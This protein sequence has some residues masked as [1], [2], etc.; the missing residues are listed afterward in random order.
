MYPVYSIFMDPL[1][2]NV[3]L[4]EKHAK[5]CP[6]SCAASPGGLIWKCM[7]DRIKT[8][9]GRVIFLLVMCALVITVLVLL[10]SFDMIRS[11]ERRTMIQSVEFNFQLISSLVEQDLRDL[12]SLAWWC[13]SNREIQEFLL[14]EDQNPARSISAW[15][16]LSEEYVNNRSAPYVRRLIV[17]DLPQEKFIQVGNMA[18]GSVPVT[19][20]NLGMIF[21]AQVEQNSQWQTLIQD[22]YTIGESPVFPLV[23][24]VYSFE[25]GN[26]IGT[27]FLAASSGIITDKLKGYNPPP[28][29]R[30][31]LNVG[32]EYY[33]I[34][35]GRMAL[36]E[37]HYR[38]DNGE[39]AFPERAI[40]SVR[41]SDG[42]SLTL[43]RYPVRE[44]IVLNQILPDI[45]LFPLR[46]TWP[47]LAAGLGA[48]ILLL[49]FMGRGVNRMTRE[50]TELMDERLAD[51][52]NKRDLE[53]RMLQSQINPHFLYNTL[54]SIKWM[55]SIQNASGI[56]EMTTALSRL[57]RTIS[58][59][60]RTMVPLKDELATLDEYLVIQKYRYGDSV[61]MEKKIPD[62]ALLDT[63]IPR[64][65][66]QPLIENAIFHGIEPR[67]SGIITIEVKGQGDN[68]AVS[69]T[70]NGVGMNSGSIDAFRK[71][72]GIFREVGMHN[73]DERLR[74]A[75]GTEYGLS[76]DSEEGKFT[77]VTIT[78]PAAAESW[79][80]TI[81][82]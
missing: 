17:F 79:G 35:D 49:I 77:T 4:Y 18:S 27:V 24:S 26:E 61:I 12:S 11:F 70:D 13:V 37:F 39:N 65:V 82:G 54:N 5:Y 57:L 14:S 46:G 21:A 28:N 2:N 20:Y 60:S 72:E 68:V 8:V 10:F 52:K 23:S 19:A 45:G 80:G 50:I 1:K 42:K 30:F 55:A 53:Y 66:L 59:D 16:R 71:S 38:G 51:E 25:R 76:I 44:G 31:Y 78:L 73:V 48:L 74:C 56:A 63:M 3:I 33:R 29:S 69:V 64:F 41:D 81:N 22:P 75:F 9:K 36:E 43:V 32:N 34:D 7:G 40:L 47:W 15:Q 62:P 58:R 6:V 67:G